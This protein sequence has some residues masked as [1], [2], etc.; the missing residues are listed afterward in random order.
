MKNRAKCKLCQDIIESFLHNDYVTCKCGEIS[1][2]GGSNLL[3]CAA[4]SWDNF[5][6]IDDLG[7]IIVPK[8]TQESGSEI[9]ASPENKKDKE[10][11]SKKKIMH[12]IENII[13]TIEQLPSHVMSTP[14]T[15]YDYISLLL[16][17]SSLLK[18]DSEED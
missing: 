13:S 8:I 15:H 1:I 6:R 10:V 5:L 18:V 16:I 4:K 17:I 2:D 3:K 11:L 9:T 12:S 7:N 14:I